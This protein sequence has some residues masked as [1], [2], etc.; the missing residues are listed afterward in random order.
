VTP[1]RPLL[2]DTDIG[3]DADDILALG[4]ILASADALDLKAVTTVSGDTRQRARIAAGMLALAGRDDVDVCAGET[5]PLVRPAERFVSFGHEA[6]C[7]PPEPQPEIS[8]EPAPERIVRAAREHPGL[9]ILLIGPMTNLARALALDPGLPKRVA[10][11]TLMGGHV[12]RVAIG[13]FECAPG[14]DYNLCSDA[15]ASVCVLGAG[16]STTLV[17]ADVTLQTW[18]KS[19]DLAALDGGGSAARMIAEQVRIW[20]PVQRTLFT[21]MGGDLAPDNEA[22]LHDPLAALALIDPSSIGFESLGILPTIQGGVMRTLESAEGSVMKVA[23]TVDAN[24]AAR[25]I[26]RRLAGL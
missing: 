21:G 8:S 22:F 2:L 3:S 15:E 5:R 20:S 23:T 12:R 13:K 19:E 16:F 17:T 6:R 14:I 24:A 26:A 10:G 25:E 1:P 11:I 4:L 18:M 9:E 7:L